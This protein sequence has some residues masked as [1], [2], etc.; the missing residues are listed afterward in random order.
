MPRVG[1]GYVLGL[2]REELVPVERAL[3]RIA[4]ATERLKVPERIRAVVEARHDVV[5]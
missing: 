5:D 3:S 2:E 4:A 1:P